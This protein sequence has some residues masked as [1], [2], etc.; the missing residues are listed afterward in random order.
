MLFF[1]SLK[2]RRDAGT[3]ARGDPFLVCCFLQGKAGTAL[4]RKNTFPG[5]TVMGLDVL[6]MLA[7]TVIAALALFLF[8]R[9]GKG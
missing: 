6:N 8:S 2:A 7:I 1:L 4:C 3:L 5:G 9:L